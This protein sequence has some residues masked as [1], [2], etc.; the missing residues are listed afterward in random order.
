MA[1]VDLPD[2]H[3][4]VNVDINVF[5]VVTLLL[6]LILL[7]QVDRGARSV[8]GIEP[9][10]LTAEDVTVGAGHVLG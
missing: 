3:Q 8:I 5:I 9:V 1:L 2:V 4:V 7:V 10:N 6:L